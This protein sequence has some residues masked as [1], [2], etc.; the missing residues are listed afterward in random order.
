ML[1]AQAPSATG[2]PDGNVDPDEFLAI[3][4]QHCETA[5]A[6]E[7]LTDSIRIAPFL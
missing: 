2:N 3:S 1:T 4:L 7:S 6:T 5:L